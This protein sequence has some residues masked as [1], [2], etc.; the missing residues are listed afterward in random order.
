MNKLALASLVVM[1]GYVVSR[2]LGLVRNMVILSQFGT[3]REFEAYV[4]AVT[5]PDIIFQV[6][7]GGAVG[8]AFI[9][10]F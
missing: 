4:A 10:V 7:A 2:L 9:P 5:V 1:A 6:L 3:G 8:S